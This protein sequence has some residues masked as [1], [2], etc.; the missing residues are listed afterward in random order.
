[1]TAKVKTFE[2]I[3]PGDRIQYVDPRGVVRIGRVVMRSPSIGGWTVNLGG[4]HGT[5]GLVDET[6]FKGFAKGAK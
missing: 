5:P 1:M 4:A 3:R 2:D 6:N